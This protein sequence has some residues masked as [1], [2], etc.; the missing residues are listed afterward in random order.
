M[1]QL[2]SHDG[3]QEA[4]DEIHE[5]H[6]GCS[7]LLDLGYL[8]LWILATKKDSIEGVVRVKELLI[9]QA[10]FAN[11][12]EDHLRIKVNGPSLIHNNESAHRFNLGTM[13]PPKARVK[14]V[15]GKRS[16]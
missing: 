5:Q 9:R 2:W 6:E 12:V 7:I 11:E 10:L 8:A 4:G 1:S 15:K 13:I 14:T 16:Q 3:T